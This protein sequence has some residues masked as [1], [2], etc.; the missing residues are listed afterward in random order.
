MIVTDTR[1]I[2]ETGD[3]LTAEF[4]MDSGALVTVRFLP[5]PEASKSAL[6]EQARALLAELAVATIEEGSVSFEGVRARSSARAAGDRATLEEQLD[7]G[8][9]DTF[10]A[11]DPVSATVS[12]IPGT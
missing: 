6:L 11:S 12:T 9:E 10:P 4:V 5:P 2:R 1:I 8:L 3:H 7:E